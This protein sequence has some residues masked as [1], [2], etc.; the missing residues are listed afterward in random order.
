M[1]G[2]INIYC[3][4]FEG[5]LDVVIAYDGDNISDEHSKNMV[6]L[7]KSQKR[8][9]ARRGGGFKKIN[10]TMLYH[11]RRLQVLPPM[12]YFLKITVK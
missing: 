3:F 5:K 2:V 9:R 6:V 11:D 8:R 4:H 1:V 12:W 7:A 10:F